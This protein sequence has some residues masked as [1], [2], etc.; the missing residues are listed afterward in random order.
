MQ[1][2]LN[3]PAVGDVLGEDHDGRPVV[4]DDEGRVDFHPFDA[5]PFVQ[6][7]ERRGV[8]VMF[9]LDLLEITLQDNL[10]ILLVNQVD[11]V[12]VLQ[13]FFIIAQ[14]TSRFPVGEFDQTILDNEDGVIGIFNQKPVLFFR[15]SQSVVGLLPEHDIPDEGPG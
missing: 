12:S 11:E 1:I 8:G 4:P 10:P 5:P 13:V 14:D 9:V 2:F 6:T 3:P 15:F 7:P